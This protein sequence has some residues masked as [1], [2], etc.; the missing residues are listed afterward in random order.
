[1]NKNKKIIEWY[2][3]FVFLIFSFSTSYYFGANEEF[4]NSSRFLYLLKHASIGLLSVY[5]LLAA[6]SHKKV[7]VNPI[8]ILIFPYFFYVFIYN[9]IV[10]IQ[11]VAFM[12]STVMLSTVFN[13]GILPR[14]VIFFCLIIVCIVP[15]SDIVF[16][17]S[18]YILN[19]FYGRERLL[20]GF[21]HPKEAGIMILSLMFMIL[22]SFSF[23]SSSILFI[24]HL[25]IVVLL[26][27][28]QSRNAL[29]FYLNFML[30]NYLFV[31]LGLRVVIGIFILLY[32][33]LPIVVIG[34]YFEV[35]DTVSSFRLTRWYN[36]L[37]LNA[38][39]H[40][41]EDFQAGSIVKSARYHMDNFY[42]EFLVKVGWIPFSLLLM[43]L[44][45]LGFIIRDKFIGKYRALSLYVPNLIYG[46]I[47][48]GMFST[49]N[50]LN[51]FVWSMIISVLSGYSTVSNIRSGFGVSCAASTQFRSRITG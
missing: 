15:L 22:F 37:D 44:C 42:L 43:S 47:D 28:I 24:F 2:F 11:F 3:L 21:F 45:Y 50:F 4:S 1:V 19:S 14:R 35:V 8:I 25:F 18:G 20:L 38:F 49:G 31:K 51:L 7:S 17:N 27:Y 40:I 39:G 26:F 41:F 48:S 29:L 32:I 5:A 16:N 23:A 10:F 13:G 9:G 33:V 34:M 46:F 12:L 30:F 36:H 6:L